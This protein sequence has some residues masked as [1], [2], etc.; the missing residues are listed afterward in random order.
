LN[1]ARDHANAAA[2]LATVTNIAYQQAL[3]S[4]AI[5]LIDAAAGDTAAAVTHLTE[6][7][8]QARRTTGEGYT[9]HWPIAFILDSLAEVTAVE[10][11]SSSRR[12][13]LALLDHATAVGMDEFAATAEARLARTHVESI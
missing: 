4:R 7:L 11:P 8:S 2:T 5:G 10:D 3:A 1:D 9:F 12:W 13:A 6:A